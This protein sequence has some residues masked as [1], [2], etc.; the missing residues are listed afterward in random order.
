MGCATSYLNIWLEERNEIKEVRETSNHHIAM[1]MMKQ[2]LDE[3]IETMDK[4]AVDKLKELEILKQKVIDSHGNHDIDNAT[5]HLAE[6]KIINKS[7]QKI[8]NQHVALVQSKNTIET[9][10]HSNI[11]YNYLKRINHIVS[12]GGK[13]LDNV[14]KEEDKMDDEIIDTSTLSDIYTRAFNREIQAEKE[15]TEETGVGLG[16]SEEELEMFVRENSKTKTEP[17]EMT[18]GETVPAIRKRNLAPLPVEGKI[19]LPKLPNSINDEI[20]PASM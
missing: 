15:G 18:A 3:R 8:L 9:L 19:R 12:G 16:N 5:R 14:E 11:S 1:N 10:L 7:R 6:Y 13:N 2:A 17:T 4:L 20:L